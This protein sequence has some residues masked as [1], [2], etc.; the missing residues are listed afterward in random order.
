MKW[1]RNMRARAL[2]AGAD[3]GAAGDDSATAEPTAAPAD[4]AVFEGGLG[5]VL[6]P[7]AAVELPVAEVQTIVIR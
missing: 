2:F 5:T 3:T 7:A 1:V 6:S 4:L